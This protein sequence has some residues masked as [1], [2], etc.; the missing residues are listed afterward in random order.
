MKDE[1]KPILTIIDDGDTKEYSVICQFE[2]NE[3]DYMALSPQDNEDLTVFFGYTL[4][5]E[6]DRMDV[7]KISCADEL[8]ILE[9]AYN[10]LQKNTALHEETTTYD[11]GDSYIHITDSANKEHIMEILAAFNL[12]GKDYIAA[13]PIYTEDPTEINVELFE[14]TFTENPDGSENGMLTLQNIP[15]NEFESVADYFEGIATGVRSVEQ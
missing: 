9:K 2:L 6:Y 14:Y 4:N 15:D 11:R 7:Y 12:N 8:N 10:E 1:Q 3:T 5:E 13:T